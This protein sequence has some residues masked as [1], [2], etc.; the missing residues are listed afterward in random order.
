M[1]TRELFFNNAE[2]PMEKSYAD[3]KFKQI[4]KERARAR[5]RARVRACLTPCR[6]QMGEQTRR[7]ELELHTRLMRVSYHPGD[8]NYVVMRACCYV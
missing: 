5:V 8:I 4:T 6:L 3:M 2:T 7:I 1:R